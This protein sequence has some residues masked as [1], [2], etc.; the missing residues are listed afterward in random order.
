MSGAAAW[1]ALAGFAGGIGSQLQQKQELE[2]KQKLA[3][4]QQDAEL[5]R[6]MFLQ[7]YA[8]DLRDKS[9]AAEDER[10]KDDVVS[11]GT[12]AETG[13]VLGFTK[14]G[15]AIPLSTTSD[16]Y[17]AA[18]K[19]QLQAQVA[20]TQALAINRQGANKGPVNPNYGTGQR[21]PDN[22]NDPYPNDPDVAYDPTGKTPFSSNDL[23]FVNRYA[24]QR[25]K[26]LKAGMSI[27]DDSDPDNP[28]KNNDPDITIGTGGWATKD[29]N[30]V[31]QLSK[32]RDARLNAQ[33]KLNATPASNQQPTARSG[34]PTPQ[35]I[36]DEAN[37]A[38]KRG[39]P[40]DAV[41]AKMKALFQQ[42]GYSPQ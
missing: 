17:K 30:L 11:H 4:M 26:R 16:E 8:S 22:S 6:Q 41:E 10:T 37:A 33:D 19:A 27:L 39:A 5:K 2:Q 28:D 24:A 25:D 36:M 13:D 40:Q 20:N 15:K 3:Q 42:Y 31:K 21:A 32:A 18:K 1:A 34:A 35:Q 23:D 14:S 29:S 12:N 7:Q 9:K 38:I